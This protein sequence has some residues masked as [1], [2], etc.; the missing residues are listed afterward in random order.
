M[1][2]QEQTN[3]LTEEVKLLREDAIIISKTISTLT[4]MMTTNVQKVNDAK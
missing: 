4:N 1:T 3:S 2:L